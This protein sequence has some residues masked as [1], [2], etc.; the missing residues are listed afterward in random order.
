MGF[1]GV[2]MPM[3]PPQYQPILAAIIGLFGGAH[4]LTSA[5]TNKS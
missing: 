1:A 2:L 3:V 5:A 4:G